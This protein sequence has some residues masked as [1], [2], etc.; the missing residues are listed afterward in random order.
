MVIGTEREHY[1]QA[2]DQFIHRLQTDPSYLAEY[3][4]TRQINNYPD[5]PQRVELT[6][7]PSR[8]TMREILDTLTT[9]SFNPQRYF[10]RFEIDGIIEPDN[11]QALPQLPYEVSIMEVNGGLVLKTEAD[12]VQLDEEMRRRIVGTRLFLHSHRIHPGEAAQA[13]APSFPDLMQG[14]LNRSSTISILV[15]QRG[16]IVYGRPR[17]NPL[18]KEIYEGDVRD[19][20]LS[21][22]EAKSIDVFGDGL[23]S[24]L[25]SIFDLNP[26][27]RLLLQRQFAEDTRS[28]RTEVTWGDKAGINKIIQLINEPNVT[29]KV[30]T[31]E[32]LQNPFY[33]PS[34]QEVYDA[35]G[36]VTREGYFKSSREW[37]WWNYVCNSTNPRY[38]VLT[39]EYINAF[40]DYLVERV[41]QYG[42][43][44]ESPLVILEAGAGDGRLAHFLKIQLQDKI[45]G[46]FRLIATD[47]GSDRTIQ[48]HFP[49]EIVVNNYAAIAEHLPTIVITSWMPLE[50]NW[51]EEFLTSPGVREVVMIGHEDACGTPAAWGYSLEPEESYE[52][53]I[54]ER[55]EEHQIGRIY[56]PATVSL[57]RL[58]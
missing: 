28:I 11:L 26:Q 6:A 9:V 44:K 38:E 41:R 42:G 19:L 58:V 13:N 27:E 24:T 29:E 23:V 56:C 39:K 14:F 52:R 50:E 1:L 35:F 34:K 33:L 18:T 5:A 53:V 55:L 30:K 21:Y 20:M 2:A 54:L 49:V 32:R 4:A 46:V 22:C 12:E 10:Y 57:R 45:P 15:C 7:G 40:S 31:R 25:T 36:G 47:D 3:R 16:L 8:K 43:T 17:F 48:R 37:E 51:T